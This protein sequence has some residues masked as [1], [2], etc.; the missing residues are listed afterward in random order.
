VIIAINPSKSRSRFVG[1]VGVSISTS[2]IVVFP[3]RRNSK[4][5]SIAN[6]LQCG[7]CAVVGN[8][9]KKSM[10]PVMTA[11]ASRLYGYLKQFF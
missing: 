8:T 6:P 10:M 4:P 7:M 1:H 2:V 3:K 9:N 11:T 5:V